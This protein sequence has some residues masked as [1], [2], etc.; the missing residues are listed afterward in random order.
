MDPGEAFLTDLIAGQHVQHAPEQNEDGSHNDVVDEDACLFLVALDDEEEAT[1][2][3]G[4]I[5]GCPGDV[6]SSVAANRGTENA[7]EIENLPILLDRFVD[8]PRNANSNQNNS[9]TPPPSPT[10]SVI[11]SALL[12]CGLLLYDAIM[13][14]I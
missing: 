2:I 4:D 7:V 14:M 13:H 5:D 11:A 6:S 12:L 3:F 9:R 8:A 10:T 1:D